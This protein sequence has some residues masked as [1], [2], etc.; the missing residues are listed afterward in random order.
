MARNKKLVIIHP[1][2]LIRHGLLS[3]AKGSNILD[4]DRMRAYAKPESAVSELMKLKGSS[5][6]LLDFS[7]WVILES[8]DSGSL[9]RKIADRG[10]SIA[11][12]ASVDREALRHIEKRGIRGLLPPHAEVEAVHNLLHELFAGRSS[13]CSQ[14]STTP[15]S[16]V[17]R[18]SILQL[19]ILRSL[20]R[21]R[22]ER[23]VATE[24]GMSHRAVKDHVSFTR[25]KLGFERTTQLVA[26]F[27]GYLGEMPLP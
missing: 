11:L 26:A 18:L 24:L 25:K 16:Q 17:Y 8:Q 3:A 12:L 1:C 21:G 9:I 5:I 10:V 23:Q 27:A 13:L 15:E 7:A 14:D 6:V 4:G 19:K 22:L 20:C 2:A